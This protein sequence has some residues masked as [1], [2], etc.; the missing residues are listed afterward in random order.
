MS[1]VV[2]S[3]GYGVTP[4]R[5]SGHIRS[6][7]VTRSVTSGDAPGGGERQHGKNGKNGEESEIAGLT[8]VIVIRLTAGETY[9]SAQPRS[10]NDLV[11]LGS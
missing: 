10:R 4:R 5:Q 11:A 8:A 9:G 1:D 2:A 3:P 6:H 7:L